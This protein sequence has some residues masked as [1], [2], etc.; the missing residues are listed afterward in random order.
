MRHLILAK[1]ILMGL[2]FLLLFFAVQAIT[3]LLLPNVLEF[4]FWFPA[5]VT[6]WAFVDFLKER[7]GGG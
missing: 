1:A 2:L 7:R 6:V 3:M 4:H 5:L